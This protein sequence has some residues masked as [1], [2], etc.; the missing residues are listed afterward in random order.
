M[1]IYTIRDPKATPL[2]SLAIDPHEYLVGFSIIGSCN[3][4]LLLVAKHG[5]LVCIWNPS[6]GDQLEVRSHRSQEKLIYK[7][8]M[9]RMRYGRSIFMNDKYEEQNAW[10]NCRRLYGFGYDSNKD[11]YKVVAIMHGNS[12]KIQAKIF[13]MSSSS[14]WRRIKNYDEFNHMVLYD[15]DGKFARGA[16]YWVG[17]IV[18]NG[19]KTSKWRLVAFDL[20]CEEF[21]E[22]APP[23]H[24]NNS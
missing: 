16:V 2:T 9:F 14:T 6:T 10:W 8:W 5:S 24:L 1:D 17:C 3:G 23:E 18:D 21:K 7:A 12:E 22:I 19:V 15:F 11:D 4:L 13:S 20:G